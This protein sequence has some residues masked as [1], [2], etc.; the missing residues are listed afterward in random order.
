M[1]YKGLL[2]EWAPQDAILLAWP[3]EA[4]DWDPILE[5]IQATYCE[6]IRQIARFETVLILNSSGKSPFE[7]LDA[8]TQKRVKV[9]EVP[10]NDTWV[11][12][13]GPLCRLPDEGENGDACQF[14]RDTALNFTFNGW[15]LKY[16][17]NLDNQ[18]NNSLFYTLEIFDEAVTI[19]ELQQYVLEGGGLESNGN[20]L[21]LYN[22]YWLHCPNRNDGFSQ[23]ELASV[24]KQSLGAK[25][26]LEVN[27]PP[28]EGDDTDGHIDTIARFIDEYTIAYVAPSNPASPNFAILTL[29]QEQ[30]K[31]LRNLEGRPLN[32]VA[33]PD[34]GELRDEEGNPLPATYANFLFVNGGLI[35]PTYGRPETDEK[36]LAILRKALPS[37]EIVPVDATVFVRWHGSIHCATMQIAKGFLKAS[38]L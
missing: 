35:V 8:N 25:K 9:L 7:N 4:T 2:P 5:E 24:L 33:L 37:R 32:L 1:T 16:A 23:I 12:D 34:V 3:H 18:V 22:R 29:L 26:L 31:D 21:L 19:G 17:A 38:Y 27:C 10:F 14:S 15:G 20:G 36:A 28:L 13:Y 30:L 11:R 6:L